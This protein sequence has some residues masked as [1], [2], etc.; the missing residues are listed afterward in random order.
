[1]KKSGFVAAGLPALRQHL[2]CILKHNPEHFTEKAL[3]DFLLEN[4]NKF[5]TSIGISIDKKK[6]DDMAIFKRYQRKFDSFKN[7][8]FLNNCDIMIDS[9]GFQFQIGVLPKSFVPKFIDGYH[10]FL[11]N[12]YGR[13]SQAFVFDPVPGATKSIIDSYK[14]MKDLNMMSY[15]KA[16]NL[17]A[18]VKR[19]MMYIHHFRTPKINKLFKEMLF[20]HNLADGFGSFAT[21]GLVSFLS[22][23]QGNPPCNMYVIPLIDILTYALKNGLKS[24]R[25]HVLGDSDWKSVLF[26]KFIERHVKE[27]HDI[28][29]EVTYDST[30]IQKTFMMGRYLFV[31]SYKDKSIWKMFLKSD[32]LHMRWKD[33]GSVLDYY[34]KLMGNIS[35]EYGFKKL[36]PQDDPIYINNGIKTHRVAYAFAILHVL[37]L[38]RVCSEWCEDYVDQLYPL[39]QNGQIT[40]FDTEV[41]NIMLKFNNGKLSNAISGRTSATYNSLKMIENLDID[42][43][44]YL[45]D[46]YMSIDEAASL[47]NYKEST[48]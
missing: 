34:Y 4:C 18:H 26:H 41:E 13:Y 27:V 39:Y 20:E 29:I 2:N 33:E 45:V 9:A 11:I 35:D 8:G 30:T 19:S 24:L 14:E 12:N 15:Q 6:P 25:F 5:L 46:R 17:P 7:T 22:S 38:F 42:Y 36:N 43:C 32:G 21:G 1:L 23:S 47:K 48:F 37:K 10:D 44:N 31:P 28:D 3:N 40:K 16:A